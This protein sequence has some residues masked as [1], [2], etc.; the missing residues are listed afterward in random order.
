MVRPGKLPD[1]LPDFGKRVAAVRRQVLCNAQRREKFW[2]MRENFRRRM[3][4]VKLAEHARDGLDN[5]RIGITRK[6][7]TSV[8][9]MGNQPQPGKTSGNEIGIHALFRSQRRMGSGFFHE[10]RETVLPLFQRGELG[11]QLNLFFRESHGAELG[12]EP[13]SNRVGMRTHLP[14]LRRTELLRVLGIFGRLLTGLAL[15]VARALFPIAAMRLVVSRAARRVLRLMARRVD[16][17]ERAAK[18]LNL[19]LI[20]QFLAFSDFDQFENFIQLINRLLERFRNFS[21]VRHGLADGRRLRRAKIS[22]FC[23]RSRLRPALLMLGAFG[24]MF[25]RRFPLL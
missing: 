22:R 6:V 21:G 1:V 3:P 17:A 23:P 12:L 2:I 4:A 24:P 16:A 15:F 7:T 11:G 14:G 18:F 8:V 13:G 19:A 9:K 25:A 10:T 5:Q 20:G